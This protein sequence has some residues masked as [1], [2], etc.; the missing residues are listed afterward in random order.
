MALT[1]GYKELSKKLTAMTSV[2]GGR[3]LRSAAMSAM[4]PA[5]RAA[6]AEAPVGDPPYLRRGKPFD[7]YPIKTHKGRL[8]TPGFTKR[9]VARKSTLSRDGRSVKVML[10][11]RPEAFYAIQFIELGTSKIPKRPWLEPAFR[12]SI[13]DV[14][15]LF[16]QRLKLLLDKAARTGQIDHSLVPNERE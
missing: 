8:R 12:K 5:L 1:S 14:D 6:R 13:N 9:N 4:L 7:P 3:L 11:V 10:G 2:A 16:R 15:A